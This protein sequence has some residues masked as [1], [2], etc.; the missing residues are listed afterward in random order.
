MKKIGTIL[1]ILV[2]LHVGSFA[3]QG[4]IDITPCQPV[5]PSI[6]LKRVRWCNGAFVAVGFSST[7]G[8]IFR[9]F[10]GTTWQHDSVGSAGTVLWGV[11]GIKVW[12]VNRIDGNEL[13]VV[14]LNNSPVK[15]EMYLFSTYGSP[16]DPAYWKQI[17]ITWPQQMLSDVTA[18]KTTA[19]QLQL[20]VGGHGIMC[21]S[22]DPQLIVPDTAPTQNDLFGVASHE[23]WTV[24]VGFQSTILSHHGPDF[25]QGRDFSVIKSPLNGDFYNVKFIDDKFYIS[26]LSGA[27]IILDSNN[28]AVGIDSL[29]SI[30]DVDKTRHGFFAVSYYKLPGHQLGEIYHSSDGQQWNIISSLGKNLC[31]IASKPGTDTVVIVGNN[32]ALFRGVTQPGVR[33]IRSL[34]RPNRPFRPLVKKIYTQGIYIRK[35]DN[36]QIDLKGRYMQLNTKKMNKL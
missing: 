2:S 31:G 5:D 1:I 6:D 12:G 7:R 25:S 8:H 10:D 32:G 14:G 9:S 18:L 28:T 33:V 29:G 36:V 35:K 24:A 27:I 15:P 4:S 3:Q 22:I 21:W 16:S 13:L 19:P 11:A 23:D 17:P 20:A 26:S 30:A 34:Q